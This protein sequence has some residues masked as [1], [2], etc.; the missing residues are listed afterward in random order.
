M[1]S[2]LPLPISFAWHFS[3]NE[4]KG[5]EAGGVECSDKKSM[6]LG[7]KNPLNQKY[8]FNQRAAVTKSI[9]YKFH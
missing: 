1:E 7:T 4:I 6:D 5:K 3:P 8:Y 9:K 2:S